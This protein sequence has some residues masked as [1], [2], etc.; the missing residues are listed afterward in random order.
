[1]QKYELTWEELVYYANYNE[2]EECDLCHKY[3]PILNGNDG[4]D[5]V[6][7]NGV[8]LLCFTCRN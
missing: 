5:F 2:I 8:Q 1:M 6:E 7:Y 4:K 3:F